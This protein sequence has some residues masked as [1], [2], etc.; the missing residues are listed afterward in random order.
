MK[1][2]FLSECD[3][4]FHLHEQVTEYWGSD[5]CGWSTAAYG[6]LDSAT[7]DGW[8]FDPMTNT[9]VCPWCLAAGKHPVPYQR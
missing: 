5:S 9:L 7:A 6:A 4:C 3:A 8:Q 1:V 2:I